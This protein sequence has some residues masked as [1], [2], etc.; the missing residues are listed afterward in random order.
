MFDQN[1]KNKAA[2]IIS[3]LQEKKLRLCC[4]ESCTGGLLSA[5]FTDVTNASK[6]F[7]RGFITYCNQAKIDLLEV[8][9]ETLEDHGAVSGETAREMAL[10][11]LKNSQADISVAITGIAGPGGGSEKKPVGLVYIAYGK[12]NLEPLVKKYNFSGDRQ[13]VRFSTVKKALDD[14]KDF[15]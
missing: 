10:G 15:I 5:L 3:L 2:E 4:A 11:A 9:A 12:T 6:V 13:S 7:D 1:L 8:K 14:L